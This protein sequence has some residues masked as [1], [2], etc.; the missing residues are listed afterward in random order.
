MTLKKEL[1]DFVGN[2]IGFVY[3]YKH[4]DA[5]HEDILNKLAESNEGIPIKARILSCHETG[6]K[7]IMIK[8]FP[9]YDYEL[10]YISYNVLVNFKKEYKTIPHS[11]AMKS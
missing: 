10:T 9:A 3:H 1:S 8:T 6:G 7:T 11:S 5:R 2:Q 4:L